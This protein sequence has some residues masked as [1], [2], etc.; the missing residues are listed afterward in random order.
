[1]I[2]SHDNN[3]YLYKVSED[4]RQYMKHGRCNGHSSYITH[5]DWSK[6]SLYL[7][8]NSGDYELLYC[9]LK[10]NLDLSKPLVASNLRKVTIS[11]LIS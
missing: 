6:D 11:V 3:L 8:S 2:G 5:A 1:M 7:Q 4:G 9:K 10:M